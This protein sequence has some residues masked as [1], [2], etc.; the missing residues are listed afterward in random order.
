MDLPTD[1]RFLFGVFLYLTGLLVLVNL[2]V[3]Q[4]VFW[5]AYLLFSMGFL[6]FLYHEKKY[7]VCKSDKSTIIF[8]FSL[9]VFVSLIFFKTPPILSLDLEAYVTFGKLILSGQSPFLGTHMS[10][11][12]PLIILFFPLVYLINEGIFFMRLVMVLADSLIPLFIF[13]LGKKVVPIDFGV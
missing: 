2:G 13:A 6:I 8:L 3:Y 11:Y 4:L 9:T 1:K 7:V 10:S 5:A 12:P